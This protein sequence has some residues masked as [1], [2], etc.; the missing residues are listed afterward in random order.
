MKLL[1]ELRDFAAHVR[2]AFPQA[3]SR[4][5][6]T[7]FIQDFKE[8]SGPGKKITFCHVSPFPRVS[9]APSVPLKK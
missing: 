2:R 8:K 3:L 4:L 7:L 6:E 9:R 5:I 1:L